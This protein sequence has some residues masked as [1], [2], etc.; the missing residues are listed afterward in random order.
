MTAAQLRRCVLGSRSRIEEDVVLEDV[1]MLGA[2]GYQSA[3]EIAADRAQGRPPI[4][5]GRQS[6]LCRVIIDRDAR[7]GAGWCWRPRATRMVTTRI[8]S[9]SGG[10]PPRGSKRIPAGFTL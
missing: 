9:Y 6:R 8:T 10:D 7:I 4:G 5:I 1:I 2:S 3:D